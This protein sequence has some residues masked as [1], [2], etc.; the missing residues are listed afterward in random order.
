MSAFLPPAVV[1]LLGNI[2]DLKLKLDEADERLA[3]TDAGMAESGGKGKAA[4]LGVAGAIAG[5][6]YE[7]LKLASVFDATMARINTQD[8]AQLTTKQMN[9]LKTSVLGLAGPTAQ[10]PEALAEAMIHVYG[11]GLKGAA[12][13][14]VLKVAA[15]GATVGHA[16]LV[17]VTN[18]L[19]AAIA[20]GIKGTGDY[21]AAMGELN[22]T[23]GA[24]DMT[25]Q[26]LAEA[27]G[28]PMLA[29]VKGY[30]LNLT[31][32]GAALAVFGDRNI[33][34]AEAATQLRMATQALAVPAATGGAALASIGLSVDS[35][36]K[37]LQSGGLSAALNDL[38]SR[39]LAAGYTS[40]SA[41]ALITQAFGKKA[42]GGLNVLIDSLASSTSNF[43][44][45]F[46]SVAA[47]GKTFAADWAQTQDT[48]AFK[49]KA[50]GAAIE[51]T[52]V[53]IGNFLMPAA[54]GFM[55]MLSQD[56]APVLT[57]FGTDLVAAF[58]SP[59]AHDAE[60]MLLATGRDVIAFLKDA[61]VAAVD[62]TRA[63]LPAAAV[64]GGALLVGLRGVGLVLQDVVN[65]VLRVFS[66][67]VRDNSLAVGILSGV[68]LAG[69]VTRLLY[70]KAIVAVDMFTT[71][72]GG[73]G[74]AA[75]G[76]A[77]FTKAVASGAVFDTMRLKLDA[78]S[79]AM[80]GLTVSTAAR[81]AADQASAAAT[82]EQS[83]AERV[84]A[85]N[86]ALASIAAA[87][88][89]GNMALLAASTSSAATSLGI[90][91]AAEELSTGRAKLLAA[92]SGLTATQMK[93]LA[94]AQKEAT[95]ATTA[96]SEATA[97]A[98]VEADAAKTSFGSMAVGIGLAIPVAWAAG[99]AIADLGDKLARIGE[100][101]L[102]LTE[103]TS[104]LIDVAQHAPAAGAALDRLTNDVTNSDPI[105]SY[106]TKLQSV[107]QSLADLVTSGHADQ[108]KAAL[109]ALVQSFDKLGPGVGENAQK[110]LSK[111][112]QALA[113]TA[114][115]AKE[116]SI[117][118]ADLA[119]AS[120]PLPGAIDPITGSA[121]ALTTAIQ[122]AT[123][124][125][126]GLTGALTASGD[127]D[128]FKK[129]LLDVT[130]AVQK[131]GASMKDNTL[132][133]LA[134]RDSFRTAANAILTYRDEQIKQK[135]ATEG[136]TAAT[137]DANKT[138]ADQATQLLATWKQAGANTDQLAAYAKE[139]GLV[140]K[141]L[142]T[143]VDLTGIDIA[144]GKLAQLQ[145]TIGG[146]AASTGTVLT[147]G[148]KYYASGGWVS[149]PGTGTSDS[150][151]AMLSNREFVVDA[152]AAART[153]RGVLEAINAGDLAT[154]AGLLGGGMG[155][156]SPIG[157]G[158]GY[159][160]GPSG[161]QVVNV[162]VQ[163]PGQPGWRRAQT[164]R[165]EFLD[166]GR[167]NSG[168]NLTTA[169]R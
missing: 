27:L 44:D 131:N 22:A 106:N 118:T 3:K 69:L 30:G 163:D 32:V 137:V 34:G 61:S 111:Y 90:E 8:N 125:Y 33:R 56:A 78:A 96:M 162:W 64:I 38:N 115:S 14:D 76:V 103:V 39:L 93:T 102:K 70:L 107:D 169:G 48:L 104:T 146:A 150:V 85:A 152:A 58:D 89:A 71:F 67:F 12:A 37:D 62:V 151:A 51:A 92:A 138:A 74:R 139:L 81:A 98:T 120:A 140:P 133:G 124:A 126:D 164:T 135:T 2:T 60:Q 17:D 15:E 166:Y 94:A 26:N 31:D 43:N 6:A 121:D 77:A 155:V 41:G 86:T 73:I 95:A 105:A 5:V 144:L 119:A 156:S 100:K 42:G 28:G 65:P 165:V 18:A 87:G 153:P 66:G 23:V 47:S 142:T 20:V 167:R 79:T 128:S 13:L 147:G 10:A 99:T 16:N 53:K 148:T 57:R 21:S 129:D 159:S 40:T 54:I 154:A 25:M 35:L 4:F 88:K 141:D 55:D 113:D 108:A 11:S 130:A 36:R 59:A 24:G 46:Q 72:I 80:K 110:F 145:K 134:N 75:E 49:M 83:A 45:K 161:A 149:G 136:V 68:V 127:L 112:N 63:M 158:I 114:L 117:K 91:A 101:P 168:T 132:E 84:A 109:A 82:L 157:A 116:V 1:F 122:N 9:D 143:N 7:S 52:G 160:G 97:A 50:T 19:D 123:D 29:T